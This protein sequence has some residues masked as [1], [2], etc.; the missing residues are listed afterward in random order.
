MLAIP[1]FAKRAE[2]PLDERQILSLMKLCKREFD[3][4][5]ENAA[6]LH[7]PWAKIL[8]DHSFPYSISRY[9]KSIPGRIEPINYLWWKHV[10]LWINNCFNQHLSELVTAIMTDVT[11]EVVKY[12][13]KK[14]SAANVDHEPYPGIEKEK[15]HIM[16]R[17]YNRGF[18]ESVSALV[19]RSLAG[20]DQHFADKLDSVTE[21]IPIPGGKIFELKTGRVRE[22]NIQ[23]FWSKELRVDPSMATEE[24]DRDI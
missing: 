11:L 5:F 6:K 19:A 12:A 10:K 21:E 13:M 15:L 14:N 23:D 24:S 9:I 4:P 16:E 18:Q 17:I 7:L 22:R 3:L 1:N 8:S 2:Y 20:T